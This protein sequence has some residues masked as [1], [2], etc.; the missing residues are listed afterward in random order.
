[1]G[2]DLTVSERILFLL[3]NYIKFEDKYEA[4]FDIT[5]DGISQ[6]CSISR[7]HAAIELKKLKAAGVIEEK[8]MHVRKGKARRKVYFLTMDGKAK[9]V[10]VLQYVK[11][12]DIATMVDASKVSPELAT[13]R[14][15]SV[16]RST[17]LPSVREFYGREKELSEANGA[18]ANPSVKMLSIRGIPGIGKTTL[19]AKL[20]S[21]LAGQR[22]FWYAAKPWDAPRTVADALGK[23]FADN[24]SR[25]LAS[26]ISSGKLELGEL[27]YLL[28]EE[29]TE[30]GFAFVFDDA[31]CS[32]SLQEFLKMFR[33]SSGSAKIIVTAESVPRFYDKSDVIA[34][35]E[36]LELELGGLDKKAALQLLEG[37]GIEG[38]TAEEL[39][40]VTH[41]HPL[42]LEMV[43]ASTTTE[44]RYQVSKF[45]EEKFYSDLAEPEKSLLQFASVFQ[46][47]IPS[48][49]IPKELK[50]AKKGSM[51]RE[52][53]PGKFEIHASL[54]EFVYNS[55]TRD[56]RSKWHSAAADYYLREGDSQERL[57][58]LMRANRHLEAEMLISRSEEELLG[59][60]NVQRLWE[61]ISFFDP[62][63]PRYKHGVLVL[64]A[65]VASM[66]GQYDAA[67]SILEGVSAEADAKYRSEALVEMGKIKSKKGELEAASKLFSDALEHARDLPCERAKALRGLGV[68]EGKLGNYAKAQELLER[69]ARDAMAAMDS[70]GMLLAHMELGNVFIGRGMYEQAIDHFSKCAAG[71]G[72]VEL[73][74][75]YVN[76]GVASAFLNRMDEA[77]LHLENAVK[78]ADETGQPRSR[79]YALTSLAEVLIKTGHAELAKEHC[80]KALEV[81]T[82]LNDRLGISAAYA[83]LGM[84]E[85]ATGDLASSEEHY[86]ESLSALEGMEVPRSRGLRMM[87]YGL[88]LE[89]KG[90]KDRAKEMLHKSKE[91]FVGIDA[92]DLVS[93]VDEELR[94]LSKKA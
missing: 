18:L 65:R 91:F 49:A 93:R 13:S 60:G 2:G 61:M 15:K 11:D 70:K 88:L 7:A 41:G 31:D 29:L 36:I 76:M 19:A 10:K 32:E 59:K 25:K 40:R 54:R 62:T 78:L 23:F 83:N 67:W 22:V 8:L 17:P 26:Y 6:A 33:H 86:V 1:M 94:G 37:R 73:A 84:A 4:P 39:V 28:N 63:K 72:P 20:A 71:F 80:F 30:N 85:R 50:H 16:K 77:R 42:S 5:Q 58:H 44:A 35:R 69:S 27:S 45:F 74:N 66:V 24:G 55:M 92:R 21:D 12:N 47:P 51:L 68:V 53:S 48:E 43:T 46:K 52:I 81:V 75:V 90:E 34:R 38:S 89:Q 3:S 82:E 64:K 9:S 14:S 57:F 87:E 56:E 79:A